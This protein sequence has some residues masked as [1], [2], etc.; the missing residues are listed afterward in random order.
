MSR[1]RVWAS[2]TSTSITSTGSTPMFRLRIPWV[3]WQNSFRPARCTRAR[4][5]APSCTLH[6]HK[7]TSSLLG[8]A[9]EFDG[10]SLQVIKVDCHDNKQANGDLQV[11]WVDAKQ[12]ASVG[13]QAHDNC[14]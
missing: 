3:R 1:W 10:A 13:K 12:V 14:S 9:Q 11:E 6:N 8:K 5:A 4:H 2:S 7:A